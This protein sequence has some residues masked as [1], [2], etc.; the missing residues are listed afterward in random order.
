[1]DGFIQQRVIDEH[2]WSS[3]HRA[4]RG[5]RCKIVDPERAHPVVVQVQH[6]IVPCTFVQL[7]VCHRQAHAHASHLGR[8]HRGTTD[9][10]IH[11]GDFTV[12]VFA[13]TAPDCDVAW[14]VLHEVFFAGIGQFDWGAF[15]LGRD[16]CGLTDV[17]KLEPVTKAAAD[18]HI[19]QM[20]VLDVDSADLGD[21]GF[22]HLLDLVAGP[23]IHTIIGHEDRCGQRLQ[24]RVGYI[25][26]A[27]VA[28]DLSAFGGLNIAD[29]TR[30][31]VQMLFFADGL[32]QNGPMFGLL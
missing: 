29:F 27:I 22:N 13:D 7:G 24:W 11:R 31:G 6:R 28:F 8:H 5:G 4:P 25:W 21:Y 10:D 16:L 20:H 3:T 23:D 19:V 32:F 12:F 2:V 18:E 30:F 1:M 17:V 26:R 9:I 15:E 14:E